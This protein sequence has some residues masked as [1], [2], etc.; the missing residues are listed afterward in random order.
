MA[1]NEDDLVYRGGSKLELK[2]LPNARPELWPG[3]GIATPSWWSPDGLFGGLA[4]Q[5]NRS[6]LE[7]LMSPTELADAGIGQSGSSGTDEIAQAE[8]QRSIGAIPSY[9]EIRTRPT[10]PIAVIHAP[11]MNP[12]AWAARNGEYVI[13][14]GAIFSVG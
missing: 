9:P 13:P 3:S 11:R 7:L 6:G 10:Q 1:W 14:V 12:H 8:S 4:E 5:S 2:P